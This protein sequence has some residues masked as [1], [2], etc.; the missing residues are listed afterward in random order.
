MT[1]HSNTEL[2]R[3]DGALALLNVSRATFYKAIKNGIFPR[4]LKMGD[5]SL[6]KKNDLMAA[7]DHLDTN[8]TQK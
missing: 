5:C 7:I 3:V 6:W 1:D 4:P 2:L 8:R